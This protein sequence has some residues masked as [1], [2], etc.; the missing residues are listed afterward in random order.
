MEDFKPYVANGDSL[1]RHIREAFKKINDAQT[2]YIYQYTTQADLI[3]DC[4]I[5]CTASGKSWATEVRTWYNGRV[6]D[7]WE[8]NRRVRQRVKIAIRNFLISEYYKKKRRID[9]EEEMAKISAFKL[10]DGLDI[11]IEKVLRSLSSTG[12]LS[13]SDSTLIRWKMDLHTDD[14]A[15]MALA[16]SRKTLYNRWDKLKERIIKR[17]E[18]LKSLDDYIFVDKGVHEKFPQ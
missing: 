10:S 11:G 16:C 13:N 14:E 1:Y 8:S 12:D 18:A 5:A 4:W 15:M 17:Y 9:A 2:L 6:I 7:S 3:S